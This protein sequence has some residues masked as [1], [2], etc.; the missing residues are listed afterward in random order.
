MEQHLWS[1]NVPCVCVRAR[2]T[3]REQ[4]RERERGERERE[5]GRQAGMERERSLAIFPV[6]FV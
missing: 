1:R 3:E 2:E 6:S 4:Y 5:A